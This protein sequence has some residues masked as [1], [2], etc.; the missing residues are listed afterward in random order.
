MPASGPA[1]V[2]GPMHEKNV[3]LQRFSSNGQH[4]RRASKAAR[5]QQP[6]GDPT[7]SAAQERIGRRLPPAGHFPDEPGDGRCWMVVWD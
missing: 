5:M 7:S 2:S 3:H 6:A 4:R 1:S